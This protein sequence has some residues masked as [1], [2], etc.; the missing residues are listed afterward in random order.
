MRHESGEGLTGGPEFCF[1]LDAFHERRLRGVSRIDGMEEF[2]EDTESRK[3]VLDRHVCS[4]SC[5]AEAWR[6]NA[7]ANNRFC[8]RLAKGSFTWNLI[9]LIP[10]L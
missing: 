5:R 3:L 4:D 6:L 2:Y 10:F 8:K 9:V 7:L 1:A